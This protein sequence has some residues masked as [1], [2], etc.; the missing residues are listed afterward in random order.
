MSSERPFQNKY[1]KDLDAHFK[2]YRFNKKI[3]KQLEAELKLRETKAAKDLLKKVR[4]QLS[5]INRLDRGEVVP[6]TQ[7]A[8][9]PKTKASNRSQKKAHTKVSSS[10]KK[11]IP[12]APS[13]LATEGETAVVMASQT[14]PSSTVL[15][16]EPKPQV[17]VIQAPP[18]SAHQASS[19][20]S[21]HWIL[22]VAVIVLCIVGG[23]G[24]LGYQ[25]MATPTDA[26]LAL[27]DKGLSHESVRKFIRPILSE[28]GYSARDID[29]YFLL[30]DSEYQA[31]HLVDSTGGKEFNPQDVNRILHDRINS[32]NETVKSLLY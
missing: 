19:K 13:R 16:P 31:V 14:M 1:V 15:Q 23:I 29:A 22:A 25:H 12:Q 28:G 5:T 7:T 3:L 32:Y 10:P 9:T 18:V 21:S 30:Y 4:A 17:I 11:E 2:E 8:T 6:P 20:S 24:Y 27:R 26:Y